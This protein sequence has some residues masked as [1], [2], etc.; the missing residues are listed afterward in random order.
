MLYKLVFGDSYSFRRAVLTLLVLLIPSV[1]FVTNSM[2]WDDVNIFKTHGHWTAAAMFGQF[3]NGHTAYWRPVTVWTIAIPYLL[4]VPVWANKLI[5]LALYFA[6][7]V[8]ALAIADMGLRA[9]ASATNNVPLMVLAAVFALHPL[10]VESAYWISARADLLLS[11]FVLLGAYSMVRS[12]Q[13][14]T[15]GLPPPSAWRTG[16]FWFGLTALACGAKDTGFVWAAGCIVLSLAIATRRSSPWKRDQLTAAAATFG[17]CA[18]MSGLR[19]MILPAAVNQGRLNNRQLATFVDQLR[20]FA[21]FMFRSLAD[22]LVPITDQSPFKATGWL[23]SVPAAALGP[24]LMAAFAIGG[25][26]VWRAWRASKSSGLLLAVALVMVVFHALLSVL[27]EPTV[28]TVFSARYVD[29]SGA[30]ILV[31]LMILIARSAPQP[32]QSLREVLNWPVA[33]LFAILLAQSLL[34]WTT[35]RAAWQNNATLWDTAWEYGARAKQV[36]YNLAFALAVRDDFKTARSLALDY[37]KR[38]EGGDL[39]DVDCALY[40]IILDADQILPDAADG[41]RNAWKALPI[42]RCSYNLAADVSAFLL[43][44]HCD[45]VL[46]AL[47]DTM[48]IGDAERAKNELLPV[49]PAVKQLAIVDAAF[50]ETRCG[51]PASAKALIDRAAL[52][53]PAWA[54]DG[55]KARELVKQASSA[56]EQKN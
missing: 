18:I 2:V 8:L 28:G 25:W 10:F 51:D 55:D 52:I 5:S 43:E 56:R 49:S 22:M 19:L 1:I 14:E 40:I 27:T 13:R 12:A 16:L 37:E 36:Q 15:A 46:P 6:K 47:R 39:T 4:H 26:V 7:G 20:V 17:A 24:M 45:K 11:L 33:A 41:E 9:R 3:L 42:A 54:W 35:A 53:D 21:E 44:K 23:D 29:V 48:Q 34:T 50:A 38:Y 32:G 30:L 31:A